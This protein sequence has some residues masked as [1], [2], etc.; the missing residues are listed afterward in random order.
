MKRQWFRPWGWVY[1]PVS[2]AG[3]VAAALVA[4]FWLN[5]FIAVDR[6]AHSVSDLLYGVFPFFTC[7]FLLLLWVAGQS[8]EPAD[9]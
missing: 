9:G 7:S 4:A 1:R 2:L 6:R 8:S 3:W 5:V